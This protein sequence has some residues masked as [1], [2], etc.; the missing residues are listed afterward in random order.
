M[1]RQNSE[2]RGN[3]LEMR[4][5][6][7]NS[8]ALAQN[9]REELILLD[10][11]CTVLSMNSGAA[12]IFGVR[13]RIDCDLLSISSSVTVRETV[14]RA[15]AGESVDALLE[16]EGRFYQFYANH[17]LQEDKVAGAV[18]LLWDIT[19]RQLAEQ[20]SQEFSANVSNELKKRSRP[21]PAMPK[22]SG[23][24][25]LTWKTCRH[26]R[27]KSI[28]RRRGSLRSSTISWSFPAWTSTRA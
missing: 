17:V 16:R 3:V 5:M 9:M 24:A 12:A 10:S 15:L 14:F 18:L 20:S 6:R 26:L 2:I 8:S 19:E 23:T 4:D 1:D 22:S 25:L 21:F 11:A 28:L 13:E 7:T 27:A